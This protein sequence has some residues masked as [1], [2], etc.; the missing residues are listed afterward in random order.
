MLLSLSLSINYSYFRREYSLSV[1]WPLSLQP[2]LLLQKPY[3]LLIFAKPFSGLKLP[4]LF[5][6]ESHMEYNTRN[7]NSQLAD[8]RQEYHEN[9]IALT[10]MND[11]PIEQ[12][13]L[14]FDDALHGDILEPNAMTL[15][16]AD[17]NGRPSARIVLLKGIEEDGFIFYTNY[18]SKKGQQLA[19]NPWAALVLRWLEQHRQIRVEGQVEKIDADLSDRYFQ[20]RPKGSRIGAI[21]SDQSQI[22]ES[23]TELEQKVERLLEQFP[24]NSE[25]PRPKHWG[26]YIL[27]PE[28]IEFW[29]GRASRLHDRIEFKRDSSGQWSKRRLA[30]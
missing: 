2:S 16:T 15:A 5:Q 30:P 21:A 4:G 17:N 25:I 26:G 11:N 22:L 3:L 10:D 20:S 1:F 18:N 14:W 27:K 9:P 6:F 23:R 12:F 19:E 13:K 28:L 29:Q 24:E 7:K 8:L